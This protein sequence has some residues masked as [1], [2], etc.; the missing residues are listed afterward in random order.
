[1]FDFDNDGDLDVLN[2]NGMDDPET[3]DD[4]WACEQKARLY[5][6]SGSEGKFR[7]EDEA[8]IRG[9]AD[10]GDNRGTMS[11][12]YD[13]DGDLDVLVINHG[14]IPALYRNDGGNYY[15]Y[16]RVQVLE[17]SGRESIGAKVFVRTTKNSKVPDM[18]QEI[19]S[20]AAFLGQTEATA[21]F[22]L[23]KDDDTS[24][25]Y[26]V[27]VQ[28]PPILKR[29]LAGTSS[30]PAL[31]VND[32]DIETV[33]IYNVQRRSTLVVRRGYGGGKVVSTNGE[34]IP[35]CPATDQNQ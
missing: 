32:E 17:E 21:H 10:T 22:G 35:S 19:G 16:V 9:L 25:I 29:D 12:D 14:E 23:G 33:T 6:N 26:S 20:S 5:V 31:P 13:Q 7:M 24:T 30:A 15:D 8:L 2:G 34:D 28:W 4:D 11:F 18:I 27:R 1:M 3:T